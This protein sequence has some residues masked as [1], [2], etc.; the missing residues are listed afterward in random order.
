MAKR[1]TLSPKIPSDELF[2]ALNQ[3]ARYMKT[4]KRRVLT[5][6]LLLYTY[7]KLP[8]INA[9][10]ILRQLA[11]QRRLNWATFEENVTQDA[12]DRIAPDVDFD[13]LTDAN[14][15]IALSDDVLYIVDEGL[16]LGQNRNETRCGTEHTL[17]FMARRRVSTNRLLNRLGIT[18]HA[19]EDLLVDPALSSHAAARDHVALVR[20]EQIPPLYFREKLLQDLISLLSMSYNRNIIVVGQT[21]VG[22]RSLIYSLAQLIANGQGP[23]GLNS[24]VE[25]NEQLLQA[26]NANKF[27]KALSGAHDRFLVSSGQI[28]VNR[29]GDVNQ[30]F[31][32]SFKEVSR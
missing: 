31:R 14:Q 18:S 19:V 8:D 29:A 9:H 25:M 7:L 6:E 10:Q 20:S 12:Q 23:I 28:E 24:V 16:G 1:G 30:T 11:D 27:E 32:A 3:A 22:K 21:G 15:R 13:F 17:V 4:F 26:I 2:Q 5:A